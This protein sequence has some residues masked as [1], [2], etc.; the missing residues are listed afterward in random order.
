[1]DPVD[2]VRGSAEYRLKVVPR[3]LQRAFNNLVDIREPAQ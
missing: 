1:L 3:L 2:D